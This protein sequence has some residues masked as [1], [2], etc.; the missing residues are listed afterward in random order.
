[1]RFERYRSNLSGLYTP[2]VED[3]PDPMSGALPSSSDTLPFLCLQQHEIA[4]KSTIPSGDHVEMRAK[5]RVWSFEMSRSPGPDGANIF[6]VMYSVLDNYFPQLMVNQ[7]LTD[8]GCAQ[9]F[10]SNINHEVLPG[11]HILEV[12]SVK[13]QH[14]YATRKHDTPREILLDMLQNVQVSDTVRMT[15]CRY[16]QKIN[17]SLRLPY[18][19]QVAEHLVFSACGRRVVIDVVGSGTAIECWNETQQASGHFGQVIFPGMHIAGV[20]VFYGQQNGLE[21]RKVRESSNAATIMELLRG[22]YCGDKVTL[23]IDR[24]DAERSQDVE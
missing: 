7:I 15:F 21:R 17:V 9:A 12:V 4:S 24:R 6:G 13:A 2:V 18:H 19:A 10:S 16:P 1:M 22:V 14:K 3:V 8:G 5:E 11:D 23:K 20:S